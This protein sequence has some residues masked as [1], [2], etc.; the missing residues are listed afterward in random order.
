MLIK[1]VNVNKLQGFV[2][3]TKK[4][5]NPATLR[6]LNSFHETIKDAVAQFLL[7]TAILILS[8]NRLLFSHF[9]INGPRKR[10]IDFLIGL[11]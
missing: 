6:F 10:G 2:K 8:F 7:R 9:L 1:T 5:I 4:P 11:L 3:R